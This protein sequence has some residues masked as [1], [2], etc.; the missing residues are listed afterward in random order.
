VR[1]LRATPSTADSPKATSRL[2]PLL[3]SWVFPD[4]PVLT[5]RKS[6]PEGHKCAA[7]RPSPF[8][9]ATG[10]VTGRKVGGAWVTRC[11]RCVPPCAPQAFASVCLC[12][13]TVP[14]RGSQHEPTLLTPPVQ[15]GRR[16]RFP[17]LDP[18]VCVCACYRQLCECPSLITDASTVPWHWPRPAGTRNLDGPNRSHQ[19]T[20]ARR[21][22]RL[23]SAA[24]PWTSLTVHPCTMT[25]S[26]SL[27]PRAQTQAGRPRNANA[28]V[29]SFRP[30]AMRR[31]QVP[32][33]TA[34]PTPPHR[35]LPLRPYPEKNVPFHRQVAP[36]PRS[37]VQPR[38]VHPML[39]A[40]VVGRPTPRPVRQAPRPPHSHPNV[41]S[42]HQS[43]YR[44][45]RPKPALQIGDPKATPGMSV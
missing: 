23:V 4:T 3:P 8:T 19:P 26:G 21:H 34:R 35:P 28:D 6:G 29:I 31:Q 38:G 16:T 24:V 32:A 11:L 9:T 33:A 40:N 37:Q 45:G 42:E 25:P 30:A 41:P 27:P 39:I 22:F 15:T 5:R 36:A 44:S 17:L 2:P 20:H 7:L 13:R 14:H 12:N 18:G 43:Q 10:C 1:V